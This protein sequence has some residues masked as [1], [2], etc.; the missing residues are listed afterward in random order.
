MCK[1][2][3]DYRMGIGSRVIKR[4]PPAVVDCFYLSFCKQ[5]YFVMKS[6]IKTERHQLKFMLQILSDFKNYYI[7]YHFLDFF[8]LGGG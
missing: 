7:Q 4:G 8:F 1:L 5:S 3:F 2:K 6:A